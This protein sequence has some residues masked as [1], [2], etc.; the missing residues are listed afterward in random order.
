MPR[1]QPPPRASGSTPIPEDA[2]GRLAAAACALAERIPFEVAAR[3]ATLL[4]QRS[5]PADALSAER[6]AILQS[7]PSP[8]FRSA[9]AV[10]LDAWI[11]GAAECV[12]TEA[13]ACLR[14]AAHAERARRER[15]RV[16]ATWT[17]P[18]QRDG[19]FRQTEPALLELLDSARERLLLVSYAVYRV[20]RVRDAL[21]TAARRGV[22]LRVIVETPSR[23][24]GQSEYDTLR[25]LGPRIARVARVYYWPVERRPRDDNGRTGLLHVKCAVADG[26]N[27]F[28][29]SANLTE[30]AFSL[31]MELGVLLKGG[32]LPAQIEAHFDALIDAEEL[33]PI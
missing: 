33:I 11:R 25:A 12:S 28:L 10:F 13:A 22:D 16:E 31:N 32:L 2:H 8:A 20:P 1:R 5:V 24:E 18:E 19:I 30:Y 23:S 7:V 6:S 9:C 26:R 14:A 15:Q 3:F 29:S 17:G 21:L 4:A 27:L